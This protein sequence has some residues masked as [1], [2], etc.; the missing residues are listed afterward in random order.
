MKTFQDVL[1]WMQLQDGNGEYIGTPDTPENR[2]AIAETLRLWLENLGEE[3]EYNSRW[4]G[5]IAALE[6]VVPPAPK[7]IDEIRNAMKLH[8]IGSRRGYESRKGAGHV[9]EYTGRFGR[10][11]VIITPRYDATQYVNV[12]YYIDKK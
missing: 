11:Y 4:Y 1:E 9:E 8:H 5:I 12:E 10:G 2:E 7:T 6:I 3:I